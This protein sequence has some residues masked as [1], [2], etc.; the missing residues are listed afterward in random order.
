MRTNH[1]SALILFILSFQLN[2][3]VHQRTPEGQKSVWPNLDDINIFVNG[4]NSSSISSSTI[5]SISQDAAN[6]WNA[7]TGPNLSISST[8]S[9]AEVGRNDLYFSNNAIFFSVT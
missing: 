5:T 8:T 7:S 3:F 9:G 4:S 1:L 6:N 2:A